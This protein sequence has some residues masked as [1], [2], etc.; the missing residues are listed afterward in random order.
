VTRAASDSSRIFISHTTYDGPLARF[1]RDMLTDAFGLSSFLMPDDAPAGLPWLEQLRRAV[2]SCD[3]ILSLITPESA[4]RPWL[5]A[6]WAC[7]WM[8]DRRTT[9][10][11]AEIEVGQ[12]W[13]P[14]R[15]AQIVNLLDTGS[16]IRWLADLATRSPRSPV[17]GVRGIATE[18]AREASRIRQHQRY[19]DLE[20]ALTRL[21]MRVRSGMDNINEQDV[22][23]LVN[24]ERLPDILT[25]AVQDDAAPVKQRQIA[26]ALVRLGRP[27]EAGEVAVTI[28]NRAEIR[29]VG[30]ETLHRMPAGANEESGEW[31]LLFKIYPLL[32]PPQIRDLIA[33][34]DHLRIAPLGPY[35][36]TAT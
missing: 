12:I 14:M 19:A 24:A 33:K 6:E 28:A 13:E 17:E 26:V 1:L 21:G 36:A 22:V 4:M 29:N 31:Q 30:Y 9:P 18:V 5:S 3:E 35:S 25:I 34:M 10:L 2:L 8:S 23:A 32:G 15:A 20:T 7:F 27:G 11:L 16:V